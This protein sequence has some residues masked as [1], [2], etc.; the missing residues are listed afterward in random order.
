ME[1]IPAVKQMVSP[2]VQWHRVFIGCVV[3]LFVLPLFANAQELSINGRSSLELEFGLW[4]GIGTSSTVGVSGTQSEVKG[5]GYLGGLTYAYG[6]EENLAVTVSAGV[7]AVQ[8]TSTVG[9]ASTSQHV[10]SV[11]PVLI[12]VRYYI[13]YP[14]PDGKVRPFLA[15]GIGSYIGTETKNEVLVQ[16]SRTETAFGGRLGIGIDFHLGSHFKLAALVGHHLMTDFATPISG[17]KNYNGTG[18]G[19]EIGYLF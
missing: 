8:A 10:S 19:M 17:R 2:G 14:K 7:L 11:V 3:S 6:L 18:F 15:A 5:T 13:P 9:L 16:E 4:G 1:S 12:G